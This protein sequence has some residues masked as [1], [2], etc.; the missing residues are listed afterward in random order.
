MKAKIVDKGSGVRLL[1]GETI[2]MPKGSLAI[3]ADSNFGKVAILAA[4]EH[5]RFMLALCWDD[6]SSKHP[7]WYQI[8]CQEIDLKQIDQ[9]LTLP[10]GSVA[11]RAEDRA[12][13]LRFD[14]KNE[15]DPYAE[16]AIFKPFATPVKDDI[17]LD[18]K[19]GLANY[20][21]R[22]GDVEFSDILVAAKVRRNVSYE[23]IA[24][25]L[26]GALQN[27]NTIQEKAFFGEDGDLTTINKAF[28]VDGA[29]ATKPSALEA[30]EIY[31]V[32]LKQRG[33]E[34]QAYQNLRGPTEP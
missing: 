11:L 12:G 17:V 29:K 5:E 18:H 16:A 19:P 15:G 2:E 14:K 22:S 28:L 34:I 7:R 25:A 3:D 9:I 13:V 24:H 20:T 6:A 32:F 1:S 4:E 30:A 33:M 23:Q 31:N 21:I 10:D 27:T 8:R 26:R